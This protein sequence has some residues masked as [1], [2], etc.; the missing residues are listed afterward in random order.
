MEDDLN[1]GLIPPA[2]TTTT[3]SK[4]KLD[5]IV[6][7]NLKL[8]PL[9][10]LLPTLNYIQSRANLRFYYLSLLARDKMYAESP[11]GL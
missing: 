8:T 2:A 7:I 3:F 9:E 6:D 1:S 4:Q 10:D 5:R 11:E